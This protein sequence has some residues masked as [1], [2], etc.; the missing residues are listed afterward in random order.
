MPSASQ[1][2]LPPTNRLISDCLSIRH[3]LSLST[4]RIGCW[5]THSCSNAKILQ[6]TRLKSNILR[7][8]TFGAWQRPYAAGPA[9]LTGTR[10]IKTIRI[11]RYD[12]DILVP[13][14][15]DITILLSV[16]F[17]VLL[18]IWHFSD[19][20]WVTFHTPLIVVD[21]EQIAV[22]GR[23]PIGEGC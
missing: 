2:K 16:L 12:E 19:S 17:R 21:K 6:S 10:H 1:P 22:K 8:H 15:S 18:Y 5:Q 23:A 3:Y 13:I 11:A 9:S 20:V 7:N 4:S 14:H